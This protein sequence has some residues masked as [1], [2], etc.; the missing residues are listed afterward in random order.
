MPLLS[1]ADLESF[2][3]PYTGNRQY[4]KDPK[5]V[6]KAEGTKL[7]DADGRRIFDSLSGLWC[8]PYGHGREEIIDAVSK[9]IR[10]L[11]YSPPF[12]V[13]HPLAFELS[14]KLTTLTPEGLDYAFFVNSGS[15][16]ADTSIKMARAYWR[17]RGEPQKTR[18]IGRARS[19]H[20]VNLGGTSLGGIGANRKLYGQLIDADHLPHTLLPENTFSRGEPEKGAELA[21]ALEELVAL[22]DSSNI[23]AVIVEPMAGSTGVLP[24]PK[25]YLKRLRELCDKHDILLI[26]DEVITGFGRLGTPFAADFFGVTPDIMNLAKAL[27]NGNAPMGVVVAHERIYRTFMDNGGPEYAVE[28]PHGYTYSAHPISCAAAIASI[29][30]F[31][32]ERMADRARALAPHFEESLHSLKQMPYVADIRNL[33]LAGAIQLEHYEGE[34]ARRP[35][36]VATAMWKKGVFVRAGGDTLQ[37]APP[38]VSTRQEITD[39]FELTAEALSEAGS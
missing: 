14:N 8:T 31:Q 1:E 32:K 25:G 12:Q 7:I 34:P 20:G 3:M 38:F 13:G 29:D 24:P 10:E 39:L 9:Q 4:K 28:F 18:L 23:A 19:Y 37:F 33:G 2:W 30:I 35:I 11:D 21:D 26:F 5:L 6:V 17:L 16:T 15:E 27:T 36:E 22:H